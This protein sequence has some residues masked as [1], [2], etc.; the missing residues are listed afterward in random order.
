MEILERG[1]SETWPEW[2]GRIKDMRVFPYL[3]ACHLP[4]LTRLALFSPAAILQ[5]SQVPT[6]SFG[7]KGFFH[8]MT[9]IMSMRC[10]QRQNRLKGGSRKNMP[11]G[12]NELRKS[13]YMI[14]ILKHE[15]VVFPSIYLSHEKKKKAKYCE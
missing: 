1:G 14:N 6:G 7:Q 11:F 10:R 3:T 12:T 5:Q 15:A 4:Y 9:K 2:E 13:P 8:I